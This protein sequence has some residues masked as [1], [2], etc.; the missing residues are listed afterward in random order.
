MDNRH[1]AGDTIVA[2]SPGMPAGRQASA[3]FVP[4]DGEGFLI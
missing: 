1:Q 2:D 3:S 4:D